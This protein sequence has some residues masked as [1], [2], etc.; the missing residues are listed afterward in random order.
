VVLH[1]FGH[2]ASHAY[3]DGIHWLSETPEWAAVHELVHPLRAGRGLQR[4]RRQ[5]RQRV[6]HYDAPEELFAAGFASWLEGDE[7]LLV[8]A[9]GDA[10][11][12][13]KL[14]EYFDGVFGPLE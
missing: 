12:A 9:Y 7:A 1:E 2:A 4:L 8:L 10:G 6:K 13:A 5:H 3:G 14:K 11:A